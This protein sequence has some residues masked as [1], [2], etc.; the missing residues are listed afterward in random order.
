MKIGI[1]GS[2]Q[3]GRGAAFDLARQDAVE[4]LLLADINLKCAESLAKETGS[5]AKAVKVDARN[6]EQLE[7][8]FGGVDAV[9]SAVS[10][11]VNV[12]H[13]EVAIETGT[14]MCDLGG[15]WTIV[16]K[17]IEMNNQ[18]R[19]AGITVVPDCGLAPGMV[20]VLARHGIEYLDRVESVK[21]RVGGL[22]Q[23]P[24]PPLN[25]SLIFSVE[26]LINEYVEPCVALRD[27]K[28][29][30][31]DPLVGF[32]E[33]YFPEPFGKLEA[34]NTSGG[35]STLPYTY[36][37]KVGNMDYKTIRYPGHGHKV[38]C[39]MKLGL[40]SS[41]P[42]DVEGKKVRPRKMLETLL[43]KNLPPAGKDVTL[44]RIVVEGWKGTESRNVEYEVID[45]FDETTGLTSM[46][47]T[48]S[49]P[50]AV[51]AMMMADGRISERGV[52]TPERCIPPELFIRE[53]RSR[54]IDIK[55]RIF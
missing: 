39:L 25:Y 19:D 46:M 10:Y 45:Y 31:E 27:G 53:L 1:L 37:G 48:T 49:F 20:S 6:R 15:G 41:D 50:A 12:L 42:I 5:K 54:G 51:T 52:L 21:I 47:R 26:G 23:E 40:M 33:I 3:M 16:Q 28:V 36:Q 8:F 4:Q 18:A 55:H 44:I 11:T 2:G 29:V 13:T 17:Q 43:E 7:G 38:W 34:F 32:E 24:R 30:L 9:I 22:Q 14:H 35:T